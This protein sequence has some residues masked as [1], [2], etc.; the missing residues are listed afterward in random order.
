M[1]RSALIFSIFLMMAI[2]SFGQT[3]DQ[4]AIRQ[5][6]KTFAKAGDTQNVDD[7]ESI[8]DENYQV[9]MNRLFGSEHTVIMPRSDYLAK[10]KAKEFGGGKR[11]VTIEH[12]ELN[13]NTAVAKV[14][15]KGSEISFRSLISLVQSANGT[16]QI[17]SD[18]PVVI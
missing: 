15:L 6:I 10:I 8:L 13:G 2:S 7:F 3:T 16:W 11:S 1:K 14:L 17:V 5:T 18:M 12:I 9:I 4:E